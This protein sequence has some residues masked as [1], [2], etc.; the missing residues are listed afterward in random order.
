MRTARTGRRL[1]VRILIFSLSWALASGLLRGRDAACAACGDGRLDAGESCD[2]G[3][4]VKGDGCSADCRVE[5]RDHLL[6]YRIRGAR[7]Q[8]RRAHTQVSLADR[9]DFD[10]LVNEA[11]RD[12]PDTSAVIVRRMGMI[13]VP[14][15]D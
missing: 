11:E 2:D 8:G 15:L 1:V 3:D 5:P 13:E 6:C 9:F 14:G 12:T 4:R 7:E 10:S